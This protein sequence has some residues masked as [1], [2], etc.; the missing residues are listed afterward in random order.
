M[1][2]NRQGKFRVIMTQLLPIFLLR[3]AYPEFEIPTNPLENR[4]LQRQTWNWIIKLKTNNKLEYSPDFE[5]SI[6]I[7]VR[8]SFILDFVLTVLI[9]SRF[10]LVL[11]P[12]ISTFAYGL[13]LEF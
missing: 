5:E 11:F 6:E 8:K 12:K 4:R 9:G 7:K 3:N 1:S 10:Q 2:R 13:L